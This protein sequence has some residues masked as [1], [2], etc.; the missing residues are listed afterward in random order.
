[1]INLSG[2]TICLSSLTIAH[3][4]AIFAQLL[5]A[6]LAKQGSLSTKRDVILH[7]Q[8]EATSFHQAL[9]AMTAVPHARLASTQ[10]VLALLVSHR[11][12]YIL[13]LVSQPV[14]LCF[15]MILQPQL[16]NRV[17]QVVILA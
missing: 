11:S 16:A 2:S 14:L 5:D 15:G 3:L 6:L 12:T 17:I 9:F 13:Q 10:L 8:V 7:V 4:F 1:M